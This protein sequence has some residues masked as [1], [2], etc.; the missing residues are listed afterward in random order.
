MT[1]I[2]DEPPSDGPPLLETSLPFTTRGGNHVGYQ[3]LWLH[4]AS[5]TWRTLAI[6]PAE[7]GISTFDVAGLIMDVEL[8]TARRLACSTSGTSS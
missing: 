1:P 4:I 3:R 2:E 6:V 8:T 7:E 5:R